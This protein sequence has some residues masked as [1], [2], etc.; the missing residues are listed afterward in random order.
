MCFM[1]RN[2]EGSACTCN[3]SVEPSAHTRTHNRSSEAPARRRIRRFR[4]ELVEI[5]TAWKYSFM[6]QT[7]KLRISQ[8]HLMRAIFMQNWQ[9]EVIFDSWLKN[10]YIIWQE[11]N[12]ISM[13]LWFRPVLIGI[14]PF[15][16]LREL[17]TN[18]CE[19]WYAR[20]VLHR[21]Y[22]YMQNPL[23]FGAE[24]VSHDLYSYSTAYVKFLRS[25]QY[26]GT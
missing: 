7:K 4:S 13:Q 26:H 10:R 25:V 20:W 6:P 22:R 2:L 1:T 18:D 9:L 24:T 16:S 14:D 3:P 17:Q 11:W 15:C 12:Y 21:D 5:T 19:C 8:K 23:N